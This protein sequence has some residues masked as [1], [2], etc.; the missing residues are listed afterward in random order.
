VP[1]DLAARSGGRA[2]RPGR[3]RHHLGAAD[4]V[5]HEWLERLVTEAAARR[6]PVYAALSYDVLRRSIRPDA[7][8]STVIDGVNQ[9]QR[10]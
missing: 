3:G 4:L 5:S 7:L 2:R 10:K 9:H 8:D 1:V 6:L